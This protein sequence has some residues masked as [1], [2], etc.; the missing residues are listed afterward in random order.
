MV[1]ELDPQNDADGIPLLRTSSEYLALFV[2]VEGR[3]E[4]GKKGMKG[5]C[6]DPEGATSSDRQYRVK[7]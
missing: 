1:A 4:N 5:G 2:C 7:P 6:K 3:K